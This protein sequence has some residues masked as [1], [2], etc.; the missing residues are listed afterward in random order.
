MLIHNRITNRGVSDSPVHDLLSYVLDQI[1]HAHGIK[2]PPHA[3]VIRIIT[4]GDDPFPRVPVT[5]IG[6]VCPENGDT[7]LAGSAFTS[8]STPFTIIASRYPMSVP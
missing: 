3:F 2:E 4:H 7:Q 8:Y 5:R 6:A 1:D